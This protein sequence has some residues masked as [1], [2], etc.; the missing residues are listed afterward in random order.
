MLAMSAS[1]AVDARALA[2]EGRK[3]QWAPT[4][5]SSALNARAVFAGESRGAAN[6]YAGEGG[7]T[8]AGSGEARYYDP[9]LGIFRS[10][11][12][13]EGALG[14]APSLHRN[15]YAQG[16]PLRYR[17]PNGRCIDVVNGRASVSTCVESAKAYYGYYAGIGLFAAKAAVSSMDLMTW[18]SVSHIASEVRHLGESDQ[19][20][21]GREMRESFD[22]S[23]N[24]VK[25]PVETATRGFNR[26]ADGVLEKLDQGDSFGVGV[27]GGELTSTVLTAVDGAWSLPSILK[28]GLS[29]ENSS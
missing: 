27:E 8:A 24:T 15:A 12:S 20:W 2:H 22:S 9:K 11:D 10:R 4:R 6:P 19:S 5:N 29:P 28:G 26:W 13:F 23:V 16:N 25:H 7:A 21:R 17:D 3:T 18:G 14:E 1:A